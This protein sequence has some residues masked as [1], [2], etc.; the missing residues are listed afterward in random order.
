[1]STTVTR[2]SLWRNR[3][4]W[5]V[6]LATVLAAAGYGILNVRREAATAAEKNAASAIPAQRTHVHALGR[7]EPEGTILALAPYSGNEGAIVERLLVHEG[8][9]VVE[10]TVLASLD[11]QSRRKAALQQAQ[12]ELE[13]ADARLQQVKAGAR[14]GEIEASQAIVLLAEE[15]SRVARRELLRAEELKQARAIGSEQL[16]Q[17]QWEFDRLQLEHRRA[18]GQLAGL[19]EVRAVDINVAEKQ[20]L[21]AR[22]AVA[23]AQAE[24]E[25][26]ELR[27][28]SNGRI[29]KIHT[30]RGER[31]SERGILEIG[32]VTCMQAVAE[33][34]EADVAL[35]REGMSA[36]I[37]IDASGAALRGTVVEIGNL[38]ARKVVLT[39]DP[40]SDTDAR[41][42]EVRI[43]ID[44][45]YQDS[46]ARLSNA[47][48]EISIQL[49]HSGMTSVQEPGTGSEVIGSG[50]T[51]D[52]SSGSTP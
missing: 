29:L 34:F 23:R 32:N 44:K 51:D 3:S 45:I 35:I 22:A 28:P 47:R 2:V 17:K 38:V 4:L 36:S 16:E 12:A 33:V 40:V 41:V 49:T 6:V 18:S 43:D 1:M 48:V 15:Q 5:L 9:D 31:I 39:N 46:V 37:K 10:G 13:V 42:V 8:E 7:L 20:V 25:A 50:P 21:S 19:K 24:F 11:N 14:E 30:H 52:R 26:S 27:A